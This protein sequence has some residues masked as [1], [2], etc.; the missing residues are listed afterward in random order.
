VEPLATWSPLLA[1]LV[2]LSMIACGVL[3]PAVT[4][5][6]LWRI[7][8]DHR[9]GPSIGLR[10]SLT[11]IGFSMVLEIVI[12]VTLGIWLWRPATGLSLTVVL[13][14]AGFA[15]APGGPLRSLVRWRNQRGPSA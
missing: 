15:A 5:L 4:I 14:A 7:A 8:R 1:G 9:E 13:V 10:E 12:E 6:G 2:E 11:L 3:L